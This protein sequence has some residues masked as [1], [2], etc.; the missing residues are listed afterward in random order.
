MSC[1]IG[2]E[3]LIISNWLISSSCFFLVAI[4][5]VASTASV[6]VV[7]NDRYRPAEY[8]PVDC[9]AVDPSTLEPEQPAWV[10]QLMKVR[11][12]MRY[13]L[14]LEMP[15]D[16]IGSIFSVNS[17][18]KFVVLEVSCVFMNFNFWFFFCC[19]D[20]VREYKS[21]EWTRSRDNQLVDLASTI[22]D[23]KA[24]DIADLKETQLEIE[25]SQKLLY[26]FLDEISMEVLRMRFSLIKMLNKQINVCSFLAYLCVGWKCV[27]VRMCVWCESV[28]SLLNFVLLLGNVALHWHE[29]QFNQPR[30]NVCVAVIVVTV[31]FAAT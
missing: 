23:K 9:R 11:K 1:S 2:C 24:V 19:T 16:I 4:L 22:A 3:R 15:T 20:V 31:D 26:P 27:Y 21:I 8:L 25:P 29:R 7:L 28:V 10:L 13:F 30:L 18:G 12:L 14:G 6:V 5:V 17:P